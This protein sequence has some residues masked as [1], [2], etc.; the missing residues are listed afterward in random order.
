MDEFPIYLRGNALG[1]TG[2]T[3]VLGIGDEKQTRQL[4]RQ[5][6]SCPPDQF[7]G[8]GNTDSFVDDERKRFGWKEFSFGQV[9]FEMST[10]YFFLNNHIE[11]YYMSQFLKASNFGT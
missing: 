9:E 1:P 3:A 4:Q 2:F 7:R 10:L 5:F 11:F 8:G 6:F